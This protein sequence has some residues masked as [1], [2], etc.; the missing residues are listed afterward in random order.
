MQ[1]KELGLFVLKCLE[2]SAVPGGRSLDDLDVLGG[3][4]LDRSA[5]LSD[6]LLGEFE[7]PVERGDLDL[8][9]VD[10]V[11][12][13][14]ACPAVAGSASNAAEVFVEATYPAVLAVDQA[15]SAVV[16]CQAALEVVQVTAWPIPGRSLGVESRLDAVKDRPVNELGV[17]PLDCLSM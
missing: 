16:A 13:G 3:Y 7:R 14:F 5:D 2:A 11:V 17:S 12:P 15:C 4:R 10:A 1:F 6:G 8:D 9:F